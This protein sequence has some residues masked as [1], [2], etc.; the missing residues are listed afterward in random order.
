MPAP[1]I[2]VSHFSTLSIGLYTV[3]WNF[4]G[5]DNATS[6][7]GEVTRPVR[8]YF[9]SVCL[10]FLLVISIYILATLAVHQSGID[11]KNFKEGDFPLVGEL[12]GGHWLG[13]LLTPGGMGH[14]LGLY[15]AG[16]FFLFPL[17]KGMGAVHP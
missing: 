8:S 5:W 15:S 2:R 14:A 3:M 16:L 13:I 11:T 12:I 1:V 6:Y 9:T 10:A 4:I 17:P 7:A